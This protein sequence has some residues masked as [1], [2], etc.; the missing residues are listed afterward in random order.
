MSI[1][2]AAEALHWLFSVTSNP[3]VQSIVIQSIGGL[4]M[5]SEE[6][7]LALRGDDMAMDGFAGL[8]AQPCPEEGLLL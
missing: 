5:A 3:T 2:L 7:L 4:P 6:K 1:N 8:F